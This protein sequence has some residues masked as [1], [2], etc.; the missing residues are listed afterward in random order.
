MLLIS[1]QQR[2]SL[3]SDFEITY[4]IIPYCIH[5]FITLASIKQWKTNKI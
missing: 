4:P 1:S 3:S 2:A 5:S